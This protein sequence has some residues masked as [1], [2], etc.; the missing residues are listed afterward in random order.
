MQNWIDSA[1]KQR[2]LD[3]E[4]KYGPIR[5]KSDPRCFRREA[6]EELLDTL[7]YAQWSFQKGEMTRSHFQRIDRTTR[8]AIRLIEEAC[9]DKFQWEMEWVNDS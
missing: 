9:A 6:L 7:N 3:H 1:R 4:P 5:P 8:I 2:E